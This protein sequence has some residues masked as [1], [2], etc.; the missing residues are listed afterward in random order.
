MKSIL[1]PI[2]FS[3]SSLN[4]IEYAANI[5]QKYGGRLFL[6]H[7]VLTSKS[8]QIHDSRSLVEKLKAIAEQT[9]KN[10]TLSAPCITDLIEHPDQPSKGIIRYATENKMDCI[11]MGTNGVM[12]VEEAF[13]GSNTSRV[14]MQSQV[15]V[16]SIPESA[17]FK[18]LATIVYASDFEKDDKVNIGHLF[19]WFNDAGT[20]RVVNVTHKANLVSK[21]GLELHKLDI[22]KELPNRKIEFDL[23][24]SSEDV[25][26]V[27]DRYTLNEQADMLVLL[28]KNRSFF[29]R[30]FNA[31]L[32]K[33]MV[34]FTSYP[35]LVFKT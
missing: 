30:I 2:D 23:I 5:A 18:G 21:A 25:D 17:K 9:D 16:L 24:E 11:V 20:L 10:F 6:I 32:S 29:E 26:K 15:P 4:A 35:V 33:R 31:S 13:F 3:P 34:Y 7:V 12:D 28:S 14:I 19:E 27:L 22:T 8:G 1:C